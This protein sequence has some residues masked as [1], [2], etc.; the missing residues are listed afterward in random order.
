MNAIELINFIKQQPL[1]SHAV[2]ILV[3]GKPILKV[4]LIEGEE[5][6][7]AFNLLIYEHKQM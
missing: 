2:P 1:I 7:Y 3:D 6:G 4:E 5:C